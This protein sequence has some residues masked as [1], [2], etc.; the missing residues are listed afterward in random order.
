MSSALTDAD[1]DAGLREA[2]CF[3]APRE[4]KGDNQP[5]SLLNKKMRRHWQGLFEGI[6]TLRARATAAEDKLRDRE[7]E[8]GRLREAYRAARYLSGLYRRCWLGRSVRD[9]GEAEAAYDSARAALASTE[10]HA[11]SEETTDVSGS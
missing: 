1:Q 11:R 9:L 10:H 7:A 6:A 3:F 2:M 5:I 8:I 4:D